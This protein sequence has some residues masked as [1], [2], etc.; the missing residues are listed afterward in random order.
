MQVSIRDRHALLA[1][2]PAALS[3][4]ARFVGWNQRETYRE[5]SDIYVGE[6]LP[7]IIVPRTVHL[8][9][10]ASIVAELIKTFAQVSG[11][12]E[13][14][15]Y[16]SLVTA[17]RDVVRIRAAESDDGSLSLDDGVNLVRGA[18]SMVL[19]AACSLQDPRPVYRPGANR[20]AVEL[21]RQMRLGQTDQGSFVITMLTPVVPPPM[22]MLFEDLDDNNAPIARRVTKRI[23]EALAAARQAAEQAVAGDSDAFGETV[24]KGVSANLCEAL[25]RIITPFPTLDV[26][27]LW[28][29]T[30][31]IAMPA[32]VIRFGQSDAALLGE[33]AR[34]LRARAPKPDKCLQGFVRILKRDG[35]ELDGT[36]R[37]KTE[38]DGQQQ[39]V[40]AV[41]EQSDYERAVLAHN[42]RA[43][44]ILK[45][46]LERLG[47]RWRLL[48]A[49]IEGVLRDEEQELEDGQT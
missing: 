40:E 1:I 38:I 44:V 13:L 43:P 11:Q 9:D 5:R 18:R 24:T 45:G 47:H 49:H 22:P 4:Y 48:N 19:A 31:P 39:S 27:V 2:S 36:I 10:Y 21:L 20:E 6:N 29:R 14:T 37:L 41:L 12:D 15:I 25:V 34:S 33:A 42:D 26:C 23:Y 7:E 17:D 32:T 8:G 16:R 30:R 3:A 46:D 35:E 28:A